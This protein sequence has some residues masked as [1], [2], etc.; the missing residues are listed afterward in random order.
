MGRKGQKK[1]AHKGKAVAPKHRLQTRAWTSLKMSQPKSQA[2]N[3]PVKRGK[4]SRLSSSEEE[5]EEKEDDL[6]E[7]E[8][9][10]SSED[11]SSD[12]QHKKPLVARRS[13]MS[14]EHAPRFRKA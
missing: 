8:H 1:G 2:Q 13:Q 10:E 3:T 5:E 14:Q 12:S 4:V 11:N 9:Q 6:D 7:D